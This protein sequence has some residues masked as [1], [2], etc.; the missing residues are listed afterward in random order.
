MRYASATHQLAHFRARPPQ[1]T[2]TIRDASVVIYFVRITN[3]ADFF[4][5]SSPRT[6][7]KLLIADSPI[8]EVTCQSKYQCWRVK[9][10]RL[11]RRGYERR[12]VRGDSRREEMRLTVRCKAADRP[13]RFDV[14]VVI[15]DVNYR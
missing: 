13:I 5:V 12:N 8:Q 6:C 1:K 10:K 9:K 4:F 2:D 7:V 3:T 15:V 14:V 11:K